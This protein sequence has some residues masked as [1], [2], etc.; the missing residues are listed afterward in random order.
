MQHCDLIADLLFFELCELVNIL[1]ALSA[2]TSVGG[3]FATKKARMKA[4]STHSCRLS[5]NDHIPISLKNL[6]YK[7]KH[8]KQ[9]IIICMIF[10]VGMH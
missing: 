10:I 4:A 6:T 7:M 1:S 8:F 2:N 3:L 5:S 9:I